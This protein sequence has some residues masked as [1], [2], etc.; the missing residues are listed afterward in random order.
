MGKRSVKEDLRIHRQ[1][2]R[3]KEKDKIY[4]EEEDGEITDQ[5]SHE[6]GFR[7]RKAG[8]AKGG[9]SS[10]MGP[11]KTNDSK[12]ISEASICMV[13]RYPAGN[14]A[15]GIPPWRRRFVVLFTRGDH[16]EFYRTDN[17]T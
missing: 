11:M 10:A 7:I 13:S 2:G 9:M 14:T 8:T 3:E 5:D 16:D 17:E 1:A 12:T 15:A 6:P 4:L